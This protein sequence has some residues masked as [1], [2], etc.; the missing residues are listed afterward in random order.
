MDLGVRDTGGGQLLPDL[1]EHVQWCYR[2]V[3]Y[4][5]DYP[6]KQE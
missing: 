2:Y 3:R 5:T 4:A 6:G 1:Q